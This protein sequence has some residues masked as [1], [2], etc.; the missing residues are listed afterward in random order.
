MARTTKSAFTLIELLVVVAIIALLV[1]ILLPSLQGAREQAKKALCLSNMKQV[2]LGS[3]SYAVEDDLEQLIPIHWGNVRSDATKYMSSGPWVWRLALPYIYGGRTCVKPLVGDQVSYKMM[4]VK[5][6]PK[7]AQW[8][9]GA[10]G[11]PLNRYLYGGVAEADIKDMSLFHCPSDTGYPEYDP[12]VFGGTGV[13]DCPPQS[14]LVPCYDFVG[15]SY[16]INTCG[17]IMTY[18]GIDSPNPKWKYSFSVGSEGHA[19]SSIENPSRVAM[20]CEPNFYWWSRQSPGA[21]EN[22][23]D[24][25]FPGWHKKI[26]SDN[27][28]YCDGSARQTKVDS[29]SDWDDATLEGM[30]Y[31]QGYG[32][33]YFLRRGRTWQTDC[34]PTPGAL[35]R[36]FSYGN[37]KPLMSPASWPPGWPFDGYTTNLCYW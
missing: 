16:R 30:N 3:H 32:W 22:P 36:V 33:N 17:M 14:Q 29:L 35:I 34:Y 21:F 19:S 27:V 12:E 7:S 13:Q 11:R 18:A 4:D 26:M 5:L 9:W 28:I 15:N 8:D 23:E 2:G 37:G 1:S 25:M 20:Y 31:C 6:Y 24:Y 10:P